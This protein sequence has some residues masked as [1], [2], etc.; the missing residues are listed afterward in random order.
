MQKTIMSSE[1]GF[2]STCQYL[3]AKS[4]NKN[5]FFSSNLSTVSF[6]TNNEYTSVTDIS[7]TFL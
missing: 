7:F 5:Y 3:T 4:I 1:F 2:I 6:T